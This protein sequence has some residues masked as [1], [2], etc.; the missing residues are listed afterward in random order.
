VVARKVYAVDLF[1]GIG[2]LTHGLEKTGINVLSGIDLDPNCLY[3]YTANNKAEFR[4]ESVENISTIDLEEIYPARGIRLLA[5]C[6]PC[7][8]FS[9]YNRRARSTDKRWW[10]LKEFSRLIEGSLPDLVT[11]ENVPGVIEHRV[12]RDFLK[13]LETK[14][15]H[16]DYRIVDCAAYGIPQHRSR[17]VLLASRLGPIEIMPPSYFRTRS[18]TV[19]K[20]IKH[21]PPIRA[22]QSCHKDRMHKSS[23]LS[24]TNLKRIKASLPGGSW[25]QWKRSLIADCH[26][27]DSGRTYPGVYGRME[28]DKPAPTIT[29]QFFGFGNGRF[30]HPTQNR[31]ISLRE[32]AI[33]QSFPRRYKFVEPGKSIYVKTIGRLIGNAV[34]VKLG[35]V[36]GKSIQQHVAEI[37]HGRTVAQ[38][39]RK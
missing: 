28:W 27:K 23:T 8:T 4:L 30:G 38:K 19:R 6:A 24:K 36:I 5:G 35:E 9:T 20:A 7:Q 26:K 15:Y 37:S 11:M 39:R 31:A 29:T 33:L 18:I 34:P 16:I 2:G 21:L 14:K 10:L 25:R 17:L 1:C 32:G 12:F 22:G 3:P 13:T